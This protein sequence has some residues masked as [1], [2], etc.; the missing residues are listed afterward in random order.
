[1]AEQQSEVDTYTIRMRFEISL[2]F[3]IKNNYPSAIPL[4]YP[5]FAIKVKSNNV[6]N[7]H[8]AYF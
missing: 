1:M 8:V 4:S 2:A 5:F 6:V 7:P 3:R